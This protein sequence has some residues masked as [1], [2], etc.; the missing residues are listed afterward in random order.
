VAPCTHEVIGLVLACAGLVTL[1]FPF[2][3]Q[4]SGCHF[5][6]FSLSCIC[7]L[8]RSRCSTN[9]KARGLVTSRVGQDRERRLLAL[10]S[11]RLPESVWD[12]RVK[13][14]AVDHCVPQTP[15]GRGELDPLL[16]FFSHFAPTRHQPPCTTRFGRLGLVY[17]DAATPRSSTAFHRARRAGP[18]TG[19]SPGPLHSSWCFPAI[20]LNSF[21]LPSASSHNL[22]HYLLRQNA[23]P[24]LLDTWFQM[25]EISRNEGA[26]EG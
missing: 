11:A 10:S 17:G 23:L 18:L 12:A 14:A 26:D 24:F 2:G 13:C 7:L 19:N 15:P 20:L 25:S 6:A 5:L 16:A 8:Y 21:Y 3:S 22:V 1:R 4:A 9:L